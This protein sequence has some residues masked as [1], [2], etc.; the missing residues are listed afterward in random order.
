MQKTEVFLKDYT[1]PEFLIETVDLTLNLIDGQKSL[2]TAIYKVVKNPESKLGNNFILQADE[3]E[4]QKAILNGKELTSSDYQFDGKVFVLKNAPDVF[5]FEVQTLFD[6]E[7][8]TVLSGIYKSSKMYCSQC[9]AE[10][11]RRITL[12]PDSP[13]VMS[14]FTTTVIADKQKYPVLLSNGNK[15]EE[16]DLADG[17]HMVKWHDPFKKPAHLFAAVAGDL[18]CLEDTFKTK[19]GKIVDLKLFVETK[20]INKTGFAMHS[21]KKAMQYDEDFYDREYDLDI[22]MIVAV[23]DFNMGAMENK[24]LNIFNSMAVLATPRTTTDVLLERIQGIVAHE[25][26]HNWSGNRVGCRDWFQLSLKEGFTVFRDQGFSMH[27]TQGVRQVID[28]ASFMKSIQFAED[29]SPMSHPV[30][31][32]SYQEIDNFFTV[33]VYDK[34]AEVVRMYKTI[35][36][37]AGFRKGCNLFFETFD[38]KAATIEDFLWSMEK[39]NDTDLSQFKRWY[40]QEGTPTVEV[41]AHYHEETSTFIVILTQKLKDGQ[42]PFLIP[43]K[44]G[45]IDESGKDV[46]SSDLLMLDEE[47]KT[48]EFYNI[49]QKPTLSILRDFSAPVKLEFNQSTEDNLFLAQNDSNLYNRQASVEK[50]LINE[51]KSA[52]CKIKDKKAVNVSEGLISILKHVMFNED[53]NI[54]VKPTLLALPTDEILKNEIQ[55]IDPVLMHQA[56][57]AVKKSIAKKLEDEFKTL[58]DKTYKKKEYEFTALDIARR[59]IVLI[60]LDYLFTIN[61]QD[62]QDMLK[63]LLNNS[64]NMTYEI[65]A[66]KTL[67]NS[68]DSKTRE[69]AASVFY[70]K[71]KDDSLVMN[72][73]FG[74]QTINP[75]ACDLNK[76]KELSRSPAFDINNPNKFRAVFN[77]FTKNVNFHNEEAYEF[78]AKM[79]I[80]FD[81][82]NPHLARGLVKSFI[83]Y[84]EY[85][86]PYSKIMLEQLKRIN[87]QVSSAALKEILGKSLQK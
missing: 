59:S 31:P 82:T 33:T 2:S 15:I 32:Q 36:G 25:Y 72:S 13:D 5:T 24:G 65:G 35:L 50:V 80:K 73:W 39:A 86:K 77:I 20:D 21:L 64:H 55:P 10:G 9:E 28:A 84:K 68:E 40:I 38:G 81:K 34:G 62:Y 83:N 27:E 69:D 46:N 52:I 16:S 67:L 60:C 57:Q 66:L 17:R 56:K 43:V 87:E 47:S 11:F 12:H 70:E 18:D 58:L 49:K 1:V 8:N 4:L 3:I 23:D 22:F 54:A 44:Y 63:D 29:A 78:M 7:N 26:F 74:V 53:I 61:E 14:V 42:K 71:W 6:P 51:I 75:I 19:S 30:Q 85:A 76:I 48:F 37:D 79:I 41:E 45:L